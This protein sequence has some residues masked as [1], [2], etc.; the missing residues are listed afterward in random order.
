MTR[1]DLACTS[2]KAFLRQSTVTLRGMPGISLLAANFTFALPVDTWTLVVQCSRRV[3]RFSF[4]FS[5]PLLAP[6]PSALFVGIGAF[7][8][9][10][11]SNFCRSWPFRI[12]LPVF[13]S[14]IVVRNSFASNISECLLL[15]P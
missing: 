7:A 6:L 8:F 13:F 4:P 9:P 3:L 12:I 15:P 1:F 10:R 14:D 11:V 2:S 5:F